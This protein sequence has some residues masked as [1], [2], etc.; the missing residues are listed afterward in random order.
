MGNPSPLDSCKRYPKP[1]APLSG[2]DRG[3]MNFW[4]FLA[5][6]NSTKKQMEKGANLQARI[7][8]VMIDG[9]AFS[10]RVHRWSL[11]V[12]LHLQRTFSF[13][14]MRD[15]SNLSMPP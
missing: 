9:R 5:S 12:I 1:L 2:M 10:F 8:L 11:P 15:L 4:L 6:H 3:Q 13:G 14:F 7:A